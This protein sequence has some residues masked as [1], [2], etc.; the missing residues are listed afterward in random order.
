MDLSRRAF[1]QLGAMSLFPSFATASH[2]A[3]KIEGLPVTDERNLF[4][5]L[6]T[7]HYYGY[8]TRGEFKAELSSK[9]YSGI[10]PPGKNNGKLHWF[11][12]ANETNGRR[13]IFNTPFVEPTQREIY[14]YYKFFNSFSRYDGFDLAKRIYDSFQN[15]TYNFG[16]EKGEGWFLGKSTP[17]HP[18]V[19]LSG[20]EGRGVCADKAFALY[21]LY[22]RHK[23]KVIPVMGTFRNKISEA[24]M[25]DR[26]FTEKNYFDLDPTWNRE[27]VLLRRS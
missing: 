14:D 25:W 5:D 13:R 21:D 2:D 27:F 1:L 24:H 20:R 17:L 4:S 23:L 19:L 7:I 10:L 9:G 12:S 26:I 3:R 8:F 15:K 6:S 18:A 11:L 16:K 22:A